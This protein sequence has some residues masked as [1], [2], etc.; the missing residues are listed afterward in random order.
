MKKDNYE[1]VPKKTVKRIANIVGVNSA[2]QQALDTAK[3]YK[4]PMFFMSGTSVV[5]VDL[6]EE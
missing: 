4:K 5:V 6:Y 3:N 1:I 2:C